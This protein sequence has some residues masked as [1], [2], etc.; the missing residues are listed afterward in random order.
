MCQPGFAYFP[1]NLSVQ[2][3]TVGFLDI[4]DGD[5][6]ASIWKLTKMV[7]SRSI[8]KLGGGRGE[9]WLASPMSPITV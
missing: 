3:G 5:V 4:V 1:H 7:L 8:G 2:L 6:E 9:G